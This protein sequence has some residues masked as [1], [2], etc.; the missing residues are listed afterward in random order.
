MRCML[1]LVKWL[2]GANGWLLAGMA[3]KKQ[4]Q[5]CLWKWL[6][7]LK[8]LHTGTGSHDAL[9]YTRAIHHFFWLMSWGAYFFAASITQYFAPTY[10]VCSSI[11]FSDVFFTYSWHTGYNLNT[12]ISKGFCKLPYLVAFFRT[13]SYDGGSDALFPVGLWLDTHAVS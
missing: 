12:T 2:F 10:G 13:S 3:R 5:Q 11:H 9:R 7:S 4:M 8:Q 1:K 6:T